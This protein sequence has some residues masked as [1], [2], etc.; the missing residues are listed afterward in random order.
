MFTENSQLF[1]KCS[2]PIQ[3]V[4][5]LGFKSEISSYMCRGLAHFLALGLK[6]FPEKYF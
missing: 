5:K 4:K 1:W 6:I 3:F 2:F